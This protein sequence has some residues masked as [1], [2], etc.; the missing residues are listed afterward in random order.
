MNKTIITTVGTSLITNFLKIKNDPVSKAYEDLQSISFFELSKSDAD[1]YFESAEKIQKPISNFSNCAEISSILAIEKELKKDLKENEELHLTIHLLCTDT[2]LSPL[3]AEVIAR[4]LKEKNYTVNFHEQENVISEIKNSNFKSS[5]IIRDL[6]VDDKEKFEKKGLKNL[7]EIIYDLSQKENVAFN[8][9]GG[10]KGLIPYM[11]IIAQITQSKTYYL[12][13]EEVKSN[14]ENNLITIPQA[15]FDI[16]WSMFEKYK[17]I[18]VE[19]NGEIIENWSSW[20][21]EKDLG[22]DFSLC[23]YYD[24]KDDTAMLN[25]IG[26]LFLRKYQDWSFVYVLQNGVFSEKRAF[27][28]RYQLNEA[29][30]G[31]QKLLSDFIKNNQLSDK[32][33]VEIEEALHKIKPDNL[34]H[35]SEYKTFF[36]SKYPKANPE[37]RILYNFEYENNNLKLII[38]DFRIRDFDHSKYVNEF[39]TFYEANKENKSLIPFIQYQIL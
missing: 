3:C 34:N 17:N 5:Y 7:T 9:T 26:E 11:T 23:V 1:D 35:T 27:E 20:R 18:L 31:L 14:Q 12:Y 37:I 36:I 15:P 28:Q 25:G 10:Y 6:R 13:Q 8:I 38:Y 16:N 33:K 21:Y 22:E 30:V 32:S 19:M 4:Y 24:E 29:L 39:R 2:I